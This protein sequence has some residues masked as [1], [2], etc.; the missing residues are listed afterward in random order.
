MFDGSD[1]PSKVAREVQVCVS[2]SVICNRAIVKG[3]E[4]ASNDTWQQSSA[5]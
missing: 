2:P 5:H 3:S 1:A 4:S